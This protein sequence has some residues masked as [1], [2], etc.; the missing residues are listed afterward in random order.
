M[1]ALSDPMVGRA[2]LGR[3]R[4]VRVLAHGGMGVLYLGRTEGAAG[5][6]R[7][8][9]VKRILPHLV[10][11]PRMAGLFVREARILSELQHPGIVN[12]L[13]FGEED[14]AYVMVLEFVRGYDLGLWQRFL[15]ETGGLVTGDVA[16]QVL[17]RALEALHYAHTFMRPDGHALQ[18]VH[19]DVSPGNILLDTEGHVKLLDFGIAR[20]SDDGGE[21]RTREG[22]FKGKAAYTAPEIFRG[23]EASAQSDVFAAG[24]VL[25]K[26]LSG[27]NPF[28][29]ENSMQTVKRIA[30][31]EPS[32]ITQIRSDLRR[33]LDAVLARALAKDPEQRFASAGEFAES[34]KWCR[35]QGE[36]AV[37]ARFVADIQRDFMGDMPATLGLE[38]LSVL[39]T[40]WRS[41]NTMELRALFRP[42]TTESTSAATRESDAYKKPPPLP[43]KASLPRPLLTGASLG[44]VA[45]AAAGVAMLT[46]QRP[47]PAENVK[48]AFVVVETKP[49]P[50]Q[51]ARPVLPPEPEPEVNA[52]EAAKTPTTQLPRPRLVAARPSGP[53]PEA[54]TRALR[55]RQGQIEQCF[56]THAAQVEGSPE[57]AVAFS[58]NINGAVESARVVPDSLNPTPL[59]TCLVKVARA[60]AFGAQ[61]GRV[62]FR[63]PLR[64][65]QTP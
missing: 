47:I 63:I 15:R 20:F 32:P 22:E 8:V 12:I 52:P 48:S 18:V 17:I 36:D 65:R 27:F 3:Y 35:R 55:K 23:A 2:V 62:S 46:Q 21:Y 16:L 9:V 13:D 10:A 14:S 44:L 26:I 33:E 49:T 58:I 4:V 5:F 41:N 19:R 7:P 29:G 38:P 30:E 60:T 39:D 50:Q 34:L 56:E 64:A 53:N 54:L 37:Q 40:A 11:N 28:E 31:F 42:D 43:V 1:N 6:S 61:S 24:V 59:G 57:I 45:A 51:A 25:Y